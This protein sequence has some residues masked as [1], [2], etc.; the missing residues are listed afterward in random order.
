MTTAKTVI[1]S[2]QATYAN[3]EEILIA[4]WDKN[5]FEEMLDRKITDDE[6]SEV[7]S[8]C[9]KVI[10]YTD[11]GDQLMMEAERALEEFAKENAEHSTKG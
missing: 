9:E 2:L 3:N 7:L 4:W 1:K 6:W 10:E 11:L 5:W 8:A